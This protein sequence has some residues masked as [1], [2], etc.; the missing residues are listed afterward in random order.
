MTPPGIILSP[1]RSQEYFKAEK[2]HT[3]QDEI[4]RVA[5][6]IGDGQGTNPLTL[7]GFIGVDKGVQV[8][9]FVGNRDQTCL[10]PVTF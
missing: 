6:G 7:L 5:K 10:N 2:K 9:C 4:S 1:I 8:W 3:F